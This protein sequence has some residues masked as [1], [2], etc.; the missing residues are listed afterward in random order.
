M[1]PLRLAIVGTEN[2]HA[3]E[4]IRHL[5]VDQN[6]SRAEVIALVGEPDDHNR[7]LAQFGGINQIVPR[8]IDLLGQIDALIVTNRDGALHRDQAVPFLEA[9]VP[10]WVDKPLATTIEDADAILTAGAAPGMLTS[11]SALRWATDARH[12]IDQL[13]SIGELQAVTVTGPADPD[14]PYSGIFFYGIHCADLA[15]AIHPGEPTQIT[16][17]RSSATVCVRYLV[18]EIFHTLN[19]VLPD[20]GRQV[21]FHVD[22]V[23]RHGVLS[24]DLA[25][26][27]DYCLPG[28][29]SFVQMLT[30]HQPPVPLSEIRQPIRVLVEVRKQLG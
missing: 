24:R 4:I 15:Q 6:R 23:G 28:V 17:E 19:L 20:D 27:P 22:V 5:N 7:E 16:T 12:L 21:P 1:S 10:V 25:L 11:Y 9:G 30:D 2:S 8:A 3:H 14:S 29:N 26:G 18:G 13:D